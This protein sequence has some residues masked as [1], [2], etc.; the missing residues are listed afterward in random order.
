MPFDPEI[1]QQAPE[2]QV[3]PFDVA[4]KELIEALGEAPAAQ[5]LVE[6]G[7]SPREAVQAVKAVAP[8]PRRV[9]SPTQTLGGQRMPGS[10]AMTIQEQTM[11][12]R[13]WVQMGRDAGAFGSRAVN[14]AGLGLPGIALDYAAPNALAGIQ[15]NEALA[16]PGVAVAGTLAGM[17]PAAMA[18]NALGRGIGKAGEA[19]ASL[20]WWARGGAVAAPAAALP[21]EAGPPGVAAKD[22]EPPG[23]WSELGMPLLNAAKNM[24]GLGGGAPDAERPLSQ[25]EFRTQRRQLQPKSAADFINS[26]LA[27][28]RASPAYQESNSAGKR[29]NMMKEAQANAEKLYAGYQKSVAEEG[30]RIDKEY[31]DYVKGWQKQRQEYIDKPFAERHPTAATAM[32]WGGPIVSGVGTRFGLKAINQ[33][34]AE[35]AKAGA[36]AREVDDMTA[37]ADAIVKADKYAPR[38]A[39]GRTAVIGEAAALPVELRAAADYA[40][41]KTLPHELESAAGSRK[42]A[43]AFK[44]SWVCGRNGPGLWK[45]PRWSGI[46]CPL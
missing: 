39:V 9:S 45:R 3:P 10:R 41:K 34:G 36:A 35:I 8:E 11:L 22:Y 24:V 18:A 19:F 44:S 5:A 43:D 29:A 15:E 33:K 7:A 4:L 40:D 12:E 23:L 6:S 38:A 21:S 32:T 30:A 13:P 14:A 16:N 25:D 31:G 27:A 28:T 17:A 20:P 26:E 37:L 2:P 42:E 46:G 1:P